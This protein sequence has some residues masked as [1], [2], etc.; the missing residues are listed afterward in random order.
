M[1]LSAS[2]DK[3]KE[4]LRRKTGRKRGHSGRRVLEERWDRITPQQARK[5]AMQR[6]TYDISEHLEAAAAD[7]D[8]SLKLDPSSWPARLCQGGAGH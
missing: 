7:W 1:E 4:A 5:K 2:A 3:L 8:P 6:H